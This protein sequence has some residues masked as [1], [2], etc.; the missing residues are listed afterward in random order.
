MKYFFSYLSEIEK[1]LSQIPNH[2]LILDFDGTISSISKNPTEA[3]LDKAIKKE[4]KK[5]IKFFPLAIV[6][7]RSLNDIKNK[8]GLKQI[9]YAG[10]HGLEWEMEKNKNQIHISL[11]TK[12]LFR[13][14]RKKFKKIQNKYP[15]VWLQDKKLSISI[16]YRQLNSKLIGVFKK[17]LN[18]FFK[19]FNNNNLIE[20]FNNKKIVEIRPNI[21]WNKGKFCVFMIKYFEKKLKTKLLPIYV[22]DDTTDEDA[23][24]ALKSGVTI[25]VGRNKYSQAKFYVKNINEVKNCL[26]FLS[27]T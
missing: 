5:Y 6:S 9:I 19:T 20:V 3:V 1:R 14:I 4:L 8:V 16:H 2:L 11:K 17:D 13:L 27:R 12:N 18:L 7:G 10:N 15:G 25:R 24:V 26:Q 22:G 21:K 23:F